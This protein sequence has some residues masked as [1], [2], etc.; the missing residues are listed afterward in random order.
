MA[1]RRSDSSYNATIEEAK[2]GIKGDPKTLNQLSSS[3][4]SA[5]QKRIQ[6]ALAS[7]DTA[8][9][10]LQARENDQGSSEGGGTQRHGATGGR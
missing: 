4:R 9:R 8:A 3:G 5:Q 10:D 1:D 7:L 2:V 6:N